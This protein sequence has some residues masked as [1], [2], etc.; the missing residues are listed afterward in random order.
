MDNTID[1]KN[2]DE[3]AFKRLLVTFLKQQPNGATQ[4][5]MVIA[6]GLSKDWVELAVRALLNDFPARLE[7]NAQQELIYI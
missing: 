1:R 7:P 2:Y 3:K 5:E 6:T 4:N